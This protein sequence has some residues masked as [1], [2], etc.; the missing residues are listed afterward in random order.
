M[1]RDELKGNLYVNTYTFLL[2]WNV[3]GCSINWLLIHKWFFSR[4]HLEAISPYWNKK[5]GTIF[6]CVGVVQKYIDVPGRE[7]TP[8]AFSVSRA[9]FLFWFLNSTLL[10]SRQLDDSLAPRLPGPFILMHTFFLAITM[11]MSYE[12]ESTFP[13]RQ[14]FCEQTWMDPLKH[15]SSHALLAKYS[16][17]FLSLIVFNYEHSLPAYVFT[18]DKRNCNL[19]PIFLSPSFQKKRASQRS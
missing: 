8:H 16:P 19:S 1:Y 12:Q 5:T 11:S 9:E 7:D 4:L 17:L 10:R 14:R 3:A 15:G 6:I 18:P 13:C 2:L